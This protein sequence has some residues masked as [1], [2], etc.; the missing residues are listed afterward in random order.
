MDKD[1]REMESV[2]ASTGATKELLDRECVD[3]DLCEIAKHAVDY[4][5]YGPKLGLTPADITEQER[6][7]SI[8]HSVKLITSAVFQ[9]WHRKN[10]SMA[11]YYVL[12]EMFLKSTD[13]I[14]AEKV[15][16]MLKANMQGR[17]LILYMYTSIKLKVR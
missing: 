9:K 12:V 14:A 3:Q 1:V 6:N 5:V 7:P 15:C 13:R 11:T 8:S 2:M 10:G 16:R 17:V 4:Q